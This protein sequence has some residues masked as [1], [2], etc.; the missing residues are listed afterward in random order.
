[1]SAVALATKADVLEG[2]A[3]I[4]AAIDRGAQTHATLIKEAVDRIAENHVAAVS[5]Q[6]SAE[7]ENLKAENA[8]N[9]NLA[10]QIAEI[11]TTLETSQR[12]FGSPSSVTTRTSRSPESAK[13]RSHLAF[14]PQ[15]ETFN[16]VPALPGGAAGS[17]VP[18][19]R[20]SPERRV[21]GV[22]EN[23]PTR[24]DADVTYLD[25]GWRNRTPQVERSATCRR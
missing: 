24:S 15:A 9:P 4:A 23:D 1:M 3:M 13:M 16:A 14:T 25:E 22:F 17:S 19:P 5:R 10:S 12:A 7:L 20:L 2:A 8:D 21:Y 18:G 6:V 11:Q